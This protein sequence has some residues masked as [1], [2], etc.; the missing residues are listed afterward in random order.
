MR[1]GEGRGALSLAFRAWPCRR[2]ERSA[3][4]PLDS[5][6]KLLA[7]PRLGLAAR[8]TNGFSDPGSRVAASEASLFGLLTARLARVRLLCFRNLRRVIRTLSL[9]ADSID[10]GAALVC[11][12]PEWI[13]CA[14]Y[15]PPPDTSPVVGSR[16]YMPWLRGLL[17][18]NMVFSDP[19]SASN[20]P[21]PIRWPPNQLSSMNRIIEV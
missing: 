12:T 18:L 13:R 5:V 14:L 10:S 11:A 20:D 4:N 19:A 6:A 1:V 15:Q 7:A 8:S 9:P 2:Q 17:K 21:L 16:M 3:S